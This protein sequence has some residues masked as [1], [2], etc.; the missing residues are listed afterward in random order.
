MIEYRAS[1]LVDKKF[2]GGL[3]LD[4]GTPVFVEETEAGWLG[5]FYPDPHKHTRHCFALEP[6]DFSLWVRGETGE[7]EIVLTEEP[8]DR[9]EAARVAAVKQLQAE[10][11]VTYLEGNLARAKADLALLKGDS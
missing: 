9:D 11:R 6:D 8:P 3:K 7:H 10:R 2:E 1:L 5:G 4:R